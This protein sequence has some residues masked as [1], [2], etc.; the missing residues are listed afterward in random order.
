M[1]RVDRA[2]R[3]RIPDEDIVGLGTTVEKEIPGGEIGKEGSPELRIDGRRPVAEI[4]LVRREDHARACSG[5]RR[6]DC[7]CVEDLGGVHQRD[8]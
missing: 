1:Y 5:Q 4:G 6:R 2:N 8:L 3:S 7:L